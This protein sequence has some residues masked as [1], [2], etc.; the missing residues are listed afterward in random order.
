M[1]TVQEN[2]LYLKDHMNCHSFIESNSE[3]VYSFTYNDMKLTFDLNIDRESLIKGIT[4]KY[5]AE[6]LIDEIMW[7]M[8]YGCGEYTI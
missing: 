6:V 7:L 5:E 4:S 3:N 2:I 1:D 8:Y